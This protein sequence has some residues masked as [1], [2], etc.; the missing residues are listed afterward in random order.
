MDPAAMI[1]TARTPPAI[2][3]APAALLLKTLNLL[4]HQDLRNPNRQYRVRVHP[5][6]VES[7]CGGEVQAG[8]CRL[9]P[10]TRGGFIRFLRFTT[11]SAAMKRL[12][13]GLEFT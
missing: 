11:W 7:R 2:K 1:M 5:S 4:T 13:G 8:S 10:S 6:C 12:I 9:I 3:P